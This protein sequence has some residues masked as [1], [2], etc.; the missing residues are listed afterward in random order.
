MKL[1]KTGN[2]LVIEIDLNPEASAPHTKSGKN[3]M[4]FTTGGFRYEQGLGIAINIIYSK[5]ED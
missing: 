5:K 1:T 2:K 4:A 3:K